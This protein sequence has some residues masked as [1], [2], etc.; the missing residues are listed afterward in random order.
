MNTV[1]L[2]QNTEN[3]APDFRFRNQENLN[4]AR[5]NRRNLLEA[6]RLSRLPSTRSPDTSSGD[7]CAACAR[8]LL[9]EKNA[10]DDLNVCADCLRI[11]TAVDQA[12]TV[13]ADR[14]TVNCKRELML[15][16]WGKTN[17]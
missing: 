3:V 17:R 6:T 4:P 1:K 12:L 16:N 2:P 7:C 5:F 14:Q 9:Q 11:Y 8:S 15:K 10:L 13:R